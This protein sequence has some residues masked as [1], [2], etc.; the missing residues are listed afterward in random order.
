[1]PVRAQHG[2]DAVRL[3]RLRTRLGDTELGEP[4]R[5][6]Q[7]PSP[8][9]R[10]LDFPG[11]HGL[12]AGPLTATGGL[13]RTC[14]GGVSDLPDND[15]GPRVSGG[16]RRSGGAEIWANRGNLYLFDIGN[17]GTSPYTYSY[18]FVRFVDPW[19]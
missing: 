9:G 12:E 10:A 7:R 1:M 3:D 17:R 14:S 15:A 19:E 8:G 4:D 18:C 6:T 2:R 16:L 5:E 11:V 13:D